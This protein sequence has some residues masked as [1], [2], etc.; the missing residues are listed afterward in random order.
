M[1]QEDQ[2]EQIRT[3]DSD[4]NN[5]RKRNLTK[6]NCISGCGHIKEA[7]IKEKTFLKRKK[8]GS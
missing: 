1:I 3:L 7:P 8:E 4:R 5:S 2:D 6:P